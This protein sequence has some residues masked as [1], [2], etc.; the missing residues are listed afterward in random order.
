MKKILLLLLLIIGFSSCE[1]IHNKQYELKYVV[2]YTN[3]NDTI[4]IS[5][6]YN[7]YWYSENGIN[8]I[9]NVNDHDPYIGSAP[10]KILSYKVYKIK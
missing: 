2:Y 4:T 10:F 9:K 6:Y 8:Y 5:S 1:I 3:A 7:Y